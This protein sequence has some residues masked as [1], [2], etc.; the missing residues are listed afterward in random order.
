MPSFTNVK[1]IVTDLQFEVYCTCGAGLCGQTLTRV[2]RLRRMPQMIITPC[3]HCLKN[4][5]RKARRKKSCST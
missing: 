1:V 2:S 4:A 5:S 3:P